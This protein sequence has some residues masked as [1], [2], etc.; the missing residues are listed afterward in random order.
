MIRTQNYAVITAD[1]IKSRFLSDKQRKLFISY[2]EDFL[3][4]TKKDFN[5]NYQ[6]IRY[7]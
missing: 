3:K 7:V 4:S 1:L 5:L 2:I 6:I